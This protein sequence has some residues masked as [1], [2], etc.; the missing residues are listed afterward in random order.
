MKTDTPVTEE[1]ALV[2]AGSLFA[3][4][5]PGQVWQI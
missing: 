2:R 1:F 3:F 4:G 5:A